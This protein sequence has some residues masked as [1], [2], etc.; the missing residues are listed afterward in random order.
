[1]LKQNNVPT[2]TKWDD[3]VYSRIILAHLVYQ[4]SRSNVFNGN[5][6]AR[7]M[8]NQDTSQNKTNTHTKHNATQFKT[9]SKANTPLTLMADL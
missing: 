9:N 3:I 6:N 8:L 5:C 7:N 1:M 2:L 4:G